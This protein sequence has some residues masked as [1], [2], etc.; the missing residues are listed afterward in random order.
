MLG[1]DRICYLTDYSWS[2]FTVGSPGETVETDCVWKPARWV[3]SS[4][5][6]VSQ[7]H[8]R[9]Q[10]EARRVTKTFR[11]LDS[12]KGNMLKLP[13]LKKDRFYYLKFERKRTNTYSNSNEN[14]DFLFE[15]SFIKLF[16]LGC[17]RWSTSTA[18]S[19][20][21]PWASGP[22]G[23]LLRHGLWWGLPKLLRPHM[24]SQ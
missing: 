18:L 6:N 7:S 21:R 5:A 9:L 17:F 23:N 2:V 20:A 19:I 24:T 14:R 12:L 13:H 4:C 3:F 15:E 10:L 11:S 16:V 8:Q 1:C 22:S